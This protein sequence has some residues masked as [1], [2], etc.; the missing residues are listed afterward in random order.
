MYFKGQ[1]SS[2]VLLAFLE[3]PE[4]VAPGSQ[5]QLIIVTKLGIAVYNWKTGKALKTL[6]MEIEATDVGTDQIGKKVLAYAGSNNIVFIAEPSTT[7]SLKQ[8]SFPEKI[9]VLKV[10]PGALLIVGFL[11]GGLSLVQL[12]DLVISQVETTYQHPVKVLACA[13]DLA[14]AGFQTVQSEPQTKLVLFPIT[15]SGPSSSSTCEWL[16]GNCASICILE[17]ESLILALAERTTKIDFWDLH[18]QNY[19]IGLN[20]SSTPLT[21]FLAQE[22]SQQDVTLV[23]GG[24]GVTLGELKIGEDSISWTPKKKSTLEGKAKV[25]PGS[26]TSLQGEK[27]LGLLVYGDDQ[28]QAWLIDLTSTL[29]TAQ[30]TSPS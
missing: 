3:P 24:A 21:C 14:V 17:S 15:Q 9:T 10:I 8:V 26:V 6:N 16:A 20:L 25:Q 28:G 1:Q 30:K 5:H 11:S 19:L 4:A 13:S 22:S 7:E 27:A 2:A 12:N 29:P 18:N 23:L